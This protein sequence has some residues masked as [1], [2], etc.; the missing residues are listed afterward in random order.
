MICNGRTLLCDPQLT[1]AQGHLG[2]KSIIGYIIADTALIK[3]SNDGFVDRTELGSSDHYL[4]WFELVR[5]FGMCIAK[6][7]SAF[8][9][10]GE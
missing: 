10:N 6:K 7:Q 9:I 5:N 1:Q 8:C 2:H 4:V 3:A